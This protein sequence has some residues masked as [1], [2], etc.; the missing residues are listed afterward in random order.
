MDVRF[1][2]VVGPYDVAY[3]GAGL[4]EG[5]W[6]I[7]QALPRRL[8]EE[9]IRQHLAPLRDTGAPLKDTGPLFGGVCVRVDGEVVLEPQCCSDLSDAWRW[10]QL[11]D[12]GFQSG[13][14]CCGA[15]P[16]PLVERHETSFRVVCEDEG[17]A[18]TGSKASFHLDF[19]PT[20]RALAS[21]EVARRELHA[22]VLPLEDVFAVRGLAALLIDIEDVGS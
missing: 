7:F 1:E 22:A 10:L 8:Q 5:G 21:L 17:E 15:H 14:L 2:V 16:C 4:R 6:L 20:L 11:R 19:D 9:I 13:D 18:F 12:P 3:Q